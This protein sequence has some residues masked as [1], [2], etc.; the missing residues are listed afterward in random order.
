MTSLLLCIPGALAPLI[1]RKLEL[2]HEQTRVPRHSR[3]R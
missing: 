2:E 3:L 1:S